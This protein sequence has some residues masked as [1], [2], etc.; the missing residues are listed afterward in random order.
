MAEAVPNRYDD[1]YWTQ[2]AEAAGQRNGLPAGVMQSIVI[3]GERSNNDQVSSAKARTPFQIIPQTR[4]LFLKK[5]GVDAYLSPEN[6]AT[7][8]ALHIKES[9][10]RGGSLP[11]AV[12]EYNGGPDPSRWDKTVPSYVDRVMRGVSGS[13]TA[14]AAPKSTFQTVLDERQQP[15]GQLQQIYDAYKSGKMSAADAAE[16]EADVNAG[17]VMLPKGATLIGKAAPAAGNPLPDAILKAYKDGRMLRE[18]MI[19]LEKDVA[20]GMWTLPQGEKLGKTDTRSIAGAVSEAVTGKERSTPTTQGLPDW[21]AMPEL[22]KPTFKSFLSALGTLTGG[23]QEIAQIIKSQEPGVRQRQDEKGNIIMRSPTNGIEYAIKPGAQ[24]SDAPRLLGGLAAFVPAARAT[25]IAGSAL[26]NAGTQAVIEGTQ[27]ATGGDFDPLAV[28][29]A[30]VVGGAVPAVA[31]AVQ[32]VRNPTEAALAQSAAPDNPAV[33]RSNRNPVEQVPARRAGDV[34]AQQV[35]DTPAVF[36]SNRTGQ[37]ENTPL[38][39]TGDVPEGYIAAPRGGE[40]DPSAVIGGSQITFARGENGSLV[41][42]VSPNASAEVAPLYQGSGTSMLPRNV[43]RGER[44]TPTEAVIT[45]ETDST[46][47]PALG[48]PETKRVTNVDKQVSSR[49]QKPAENPGRREG[50]SATQAAAQTESAAA[51]KRRSADTT[52]PAPS[53]ATAAQ[54]TPPAASAATATTTADTITAEQLGKLIQTASGDGLKA[55]AAQEELARHAKI[56][57]EAMAAA[58]RSGIDMPADFASDSHIFKEKVGQTRD[59]KGSA[60]SGAMR[61]TVERGAQQGDQLLRTLDASPDIAGVSEKVRAAII[62]DRDAL[63]ASAKTLY[64]G[65]NARVPNAT[66]AQFPELRRAIAEI[67]RDTPNTVTTQENKLEALIKSP[68]TSYGDL[69]RAKDAVWDAIKGKTND[70]SNVGRDTLKRLYGALADDQIN[71]VVRIG[72]AALANDLKEANRLFSQSAAIDRRLVAGFGTDRNGSI[73]DLM[74]QSVKSGATGNVKAL[75]KLLDVVPQELHKETVASALMATTRA[76]GGSERGGFG[77]SEFNKLYSGLR[78]QEPIYSRVVAALG[79]KPAHDLLS[80]LNT[81]SKRFTEARANVSSTGKANQAMADGLISNILNKIGGTAAYVV[82][83]AVTGHWSGGAVARSAVSALKNGKA[84]Q[85]E[86]A[87]KLFHSPEFQKVL[88]ESISGEPSKETVRKL[89][90]SKRFAAFANQV[91]LPRDLP[92]RERWIMQA[93][94][95]KKK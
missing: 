88:T 50:D 5:Y 48:L 12:A 61:D 16:F 7:V 62:G 85:I 34:A 37:P 45:G 25:T 22:N 44:A 77:F 31:R 52:Q 49:T 43:V 65:V 38:R 86:A 56:N 68:T 39:R 54:T 27:A 4:D 80:D 18:D 71:N 40:G 14:S 30:G 60:A 1:P 32:A 8:A 19:D 17:K 57:P 15:T 13:R 9:M 66:K 79:G 42:N 3:N 2:I 93:T 83:S 94:E 58:K 69:R 29:G 82:G 74:L 24:W 90:T 55:V 46:I 53:A 81:V 23:P 89:A 63:K 28:A 73:K 33:F 59:I 41:I 6:A 47:W 91:S 67:K 87:G 26:A 21:A 20:G 64:E 11:R 76:M 70:Y 92:A 78:Q 35:E 95:E 36:R 10:E 51:P 72:G 84:N 75:N